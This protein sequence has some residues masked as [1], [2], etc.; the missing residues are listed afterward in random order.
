[1]ARAASSSSD[2]SRCGITPIWGGDQ[3]MSRRG[4]SV[5]DALIARCAGPG[6]SPAG[7]PRCSLA[8]IETA[9]FDRSGAIREGRKLIMARLPDWSDEAALV[10]WVQDTDETASWAEAHRRLQREGLRSRGQPTIKG[11]ALLRD[12]GARRA[13]KRPFRARGRSP[14]RRSRPVTRGESMLGWRDLRC[15]ASTRTGNGL[16]SSKRKERSRYLLSL[17]P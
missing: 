9:S 1:M 13:A 6:A 2:R 7:R 5:A 12:P 4:A 8:T 14:Y 3:R 10:H 15:R 17:S 11:A 16:R